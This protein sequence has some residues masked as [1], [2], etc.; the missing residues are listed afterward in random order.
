LWEKIE[1]RGPSGTLP[2]T[3]AHM[4]QWDLITLLGTAT[5]RLS[6]STSAREQMRG[7]S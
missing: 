7:G 1:M 6:G 3:A 5:N 2:I 4:S